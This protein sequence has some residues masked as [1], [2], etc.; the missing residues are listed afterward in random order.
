MLDIE[1][2]QIFTHDG[3]KY[4]CIGHDSN[5]IWGENESQIESVSFDPHNCTP[6]NIF[7]LSN[8]QNENTPT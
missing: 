3:I 8:K 2:G 4:T 6:V 5:M 7:T 1:I